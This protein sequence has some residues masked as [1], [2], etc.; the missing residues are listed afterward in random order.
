MTIDSEECITFFSKLVDVSRFAN[1]L[2]I[3]KKNIKIGFRI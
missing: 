2:F 3:Y 1:K